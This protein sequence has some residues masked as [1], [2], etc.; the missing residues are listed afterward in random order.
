[1][2]CPYCKHDDDKVIDSRS[3]N[4]GM[5]IRR[6]RECT[7]CKRRY[8]TYERVEETPLFVIKKDQRREL[9]DRKKVL[10]GL[11]RAFE[12]RPVPAE[13]QEEIVI[14]LEKMLE[15]KY[16]REA[17]SSVLGE[18]VMNQLA[19]IDQVAYVRFA[20]VYRQFKDINQFMKELQFLL[21]K[22]E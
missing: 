9:Y 13:I 12:K 16:E 3:S 7:M 4:E 20:S 21:K 5:V 11:H 10:A 6:R 15:E 8:T 2:L 14:E 22:T 17:P 1:M 19:R 18:F